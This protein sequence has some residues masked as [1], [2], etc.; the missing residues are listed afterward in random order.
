MIQLDNEHSDVQKLKKGNKRRLFKKMREILEECV[1]DWADELDVNEW[2][3]VFMTTDSKH[4]ENYVIRCMPYF[5]GNKWVSVCDDDGTIARAV[6]RDG[7]RLLLV[8][9]TDPEMMMTFDIENEDKDAWLLKF[10]EIVKNSFESGI[11]PK[12][13]IEDFIV[14]PEGYNG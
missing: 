10:M 3:D 1:G 7:F 14:K 11:Q 13:T 9:T 4:A 12:G 6:Y 8:E 2:L 5:K